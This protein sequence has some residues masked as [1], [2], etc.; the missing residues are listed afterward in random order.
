MRQAARSGDDES[1]QR[2]APLIISDKDLKGFD[3]LLENETHDEWAAVQSEIDYNAKV[4]F[5]DDEDDQQKKD[6]KLD[7]FHGKNI[8]ER[9]KDKVRDN[10][11][12]RKDDERKKMRDYHEWELKDKVIFL[13]HLSFCINY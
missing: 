5:S 10:N 12:E 11:V 8:K 3:E 6:L 4:D 9:E 1:Y 7:K 2:P 13:F